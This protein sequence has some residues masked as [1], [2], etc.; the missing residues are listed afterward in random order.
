M[1][2][3]WKLIYTVRIYNHDKGMK[4]GVDKGAMLEMKS[5]TRYVTDGTGLP[6]QEKITTHGEK[7]IY[8]YLGLLEVDIIKQ[9]S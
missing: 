3:S 7:E 4:F 5:D 1:K 8:K 2:K 9:T 6:W